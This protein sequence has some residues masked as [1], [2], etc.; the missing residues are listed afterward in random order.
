[1]PAMAC[2]R[3]QPVASAYA[4]AVSTD[5]LNSFSR[6]GIAAIPLSPEV[7]SPGGKLKRTCSR[8]CSCSS[9]L[10]SPANQ[11]YGKRYSTPVNPAFRAALKRAGNSTSVNIRLKFASNLGILFYIFV[12]NKLFLGKSGQ[13]PTIAKRGQSQAAAQDDGHPGAP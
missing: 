12:L 5:A 11:A 2:N 9:F 3:V 10:M 8:S 6:P 4:R 13:V 7:Q 1:Q